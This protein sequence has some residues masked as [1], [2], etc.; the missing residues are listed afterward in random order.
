MNSRRHQYL[1]RCHAIDNLFDYIDKSEGGLDA[2]TAKK[3]LSSLGM[4]LET[5]IALPEISQVHRQ[6]NQVASRLAKAQDDYEQKE[7]RGIHDKSYVVAELLTTARETVLNYSIRFQYRLVFARDGLSKTINIE[8]FE[9]FNGIYKK[10]RRLGI[11]YALA[12]NRDGVNACVSAL[13]KLAELYVSYHHNIAKHSASH[14]IE[15]LPAN[16]ILRWKSTSVMLSDLLNAVSL[17]WVE[18]TSDHSLL[19]KLMQDTTLPPAYHAELDV[20]LALVRGYLHRDHVLEN[21]E[22]I[23]VSD[24]ELSS[25]RESPA[26]FY[27]GQS[28]QLAVAEKSESK[29]E[30]SSHQSIVSAIKNAII[31]VSHW[32]VQNDNAKAADLQWMIKIMDLIIDLLDKG[33][34]SMNEIES[35]SLRQMLT[36]LACAFNKIKPIILA[37]ELIKADSKKAPHRRDNHKPKAAKIMKQEKSVREKAERDTKPAASVPAVAEIVPQTASHS[38]SEKETVSTQFDNGW[39]TNDARFMKMYT[40]LESY[41]GDDEKTPML[42]VRGGMLRSLILKRPVRDIDIIVRRNLSEVF[43]FLSSQFTDC[44]LRAGQ[45]PVAVVRVDGAI[46]EVCAFSGSV[47]SLVGCSDITV[48]ALLWNR[49]TGLIDHMH[50]LDDIRQHIIRNSHPEVNFNMDPNR[51][52][53]AVRFLHQLD[54]DGIDPKTEEAIDQVALAKQKYMQ[55]YPPVRTFYELGN[56]FLFGK[57]SRVFLSLDKLHLL[58]FLLPFCRELDDFDKHDVANALI[59]F[60]KSNRTEMHYSIPLL[61]T[62]LLYFPLKRRYP[63]AMKHDEVDVEVSSAMKK[64]SSCMFFPRKKDPKEETYEKTLELDI[65]NALTYREVHGLKL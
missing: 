36:V 17:R 22:N 5:L 4:Y 15:V 30:Q 51:M 41:L 46:F 47:E 64:V 29:D 45:Y 53:R 49:H 19:V 20:E 42:Y 35:I 34:L 52:Y 44:E 54:F 31:F 33:K 43:G 10:Y 56:L 26:L 65:K 24:D 8:L 23:A 58:C 3:L 28:D 61:I 37:N 7:L 11:R 25:E 12:Q 60:D 50:A 39:L 40:L 27:K 13:T 9:L 14:S 48:N 1:V 21:V 6:L 38:S 16:A 18:L 2:S 55:A 32:V 62:I 63:S 59:D 57:A